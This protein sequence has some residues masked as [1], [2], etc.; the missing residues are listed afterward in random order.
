MENRE[1]KFRAWGGRKMPLGIDSAQIF[2]PFGLKNFPGD[3]V[4]TDWSAIMQYTGCEDRNGKEIYEGDIVITPDRKQPYTIE[5]G[6]GKFY[7]DGK[8]EGEDLTDP[9][10]IK[11]IGNIYENKEL[12]KL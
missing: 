4:E 1:I 9:L 12:L 10:W 11:V 8:E 6:G 3:L 2:E 5:F 7:L